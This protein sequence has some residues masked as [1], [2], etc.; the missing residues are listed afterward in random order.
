MS[1]SSIAAAEMPWLTR[2]AA[3]ASADALRRNLRA[4]HPELAAPRRLAILGASDE[5]RRLAGLCEAQGIEIAA[6]ADDNPA[7]EGAAL[8]GVPV[9]KVEA[10]A[11]LA[12]DVP[13]VIASHRTL[14]ATRR[15]EAM[16]FAH[17]APFALLQTMDPERFPPHPFCAGWLEDLVENRRAYAALAD[18]LADDFSRRVL[19]AVLGYRMSGDPLL[20]EPVVEWEL[21]GPAG[22]IDYGSD[23]V[24]LDGGSYDGDSIRLFIARVG[25][26]YERILGFEPDPAT[27]AR[28]AANF[29]G[30]PRVEPHPAGLWC[31][32]TTLR[33]DG[34]ASRASGLSERQGTIEVPVT[35]IDA[36]LDGARATY[37]KMNIEGAEQEALRG[38]ART[39]ARWRPKLAI[40]AYHRA[41]DLREI[42]ALVRRLEPSYR[43]YLRQHDGGLI[44]TVLY[45][46]P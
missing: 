35:S 11:P 6:V 5:G 45:A 42:P 14:K 32:S 4:Q 27:F 26:R 30:E 29:R 36:V 21:Y 46:L 8:E 39:I 22:L 24:Y 20:L 31:R 23:E 18:A 25:G 33:F 44:E 2:L 37:I 15:L 3:A 34:A 13:V 41:A 17:A 12:R 16:G 38:A 43:L 7:L 10:L 28:L 40:S 1:A 19:D 9:R